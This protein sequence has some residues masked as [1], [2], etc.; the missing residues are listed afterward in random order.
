[1]NKQLEREINELERI[2]QEEL[3][4]ML[5]IGGQDA[6]FIMG[7]SMADLNRQCYELNLE[8]ISMPQLFKKRVENGIDSDLGRLL[9]KYDILTSSNLG[10]VEYKEQD[11]GL[12]THLNIFGT[13]RHYKANIKIAQAPSLQL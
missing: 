12:F 5:L 1:M 6:R 7:G 4:K 13:E 2:E 11:Y 9:W 8:M 10:R 3:G